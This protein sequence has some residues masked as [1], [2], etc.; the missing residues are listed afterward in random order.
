MEKV[1][2]PICREN[3]IKITK[4]EKWLITKNE[5]PIRKCK[6]NLKVHETNEN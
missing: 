6:F 2:N 4:I 5:N 3:Y 1:I